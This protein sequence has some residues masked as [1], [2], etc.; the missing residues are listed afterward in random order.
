LPCQSSAQQEVQR[1]SKQVEALEKDLSEAR[2]TVHT[3]VQPEATAATTT[4]AVADEKEPGEIKDI[5]ASTD[6]ATADAGGESQKALDELQ[7]QFDKYKSEQ[8]TKYEQG[9]MKVNSANVRPSGG[10]QHRRR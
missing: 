9:V 1:L 4:V 8:S 3:A 5:P 2:A 7:A 10:Y 6:E